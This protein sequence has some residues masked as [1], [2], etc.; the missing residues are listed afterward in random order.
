MKECTNE[1]VVLFKEL[2]DLKLKI[3]VAG[4]RKD[5]IENQLIQ[6]VGEHKGIDFEGGATFTYATN[7]RGK[8]TMRSNF[9]GLED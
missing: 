6:E 1:Q 5:E 9:K 7:K 4:K 3:D 8:R 2:R